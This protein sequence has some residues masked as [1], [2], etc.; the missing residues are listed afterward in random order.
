MKIHDANLV[1]RLVGLMAAGLLLFQAHTIWAQEPVMGAQN[2]MTW[3]ALAVGGTPAETLSRKTFYVDGLDNMSAFWSQHADP[4]SDTVDFNKIFIGENVGQ[5]RDGL[6]SFYADAK[7]LQ[8][9]I[10]DAIL[11][12]RL[13]D[14]G[15]APVK[16][17]DILKELREATI[18]GPDRGRENKIWQSALKLL[19]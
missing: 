15:I 16:I 13:Q 5:I 19:K 11:I 1:K 14:G 18:N 9:P 17:D 4:K 7:N 8:V 6:D 12:I 10:V 3:N 2:G